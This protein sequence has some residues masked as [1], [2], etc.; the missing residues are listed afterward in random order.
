MDESRLVAAA[1]EAR[2]R[3]YAPY[4]GF[5]V[6]AALLSKGGRLFTGCNVENASYGLTVCAERV[7]L[8]KAVSEGVREFEAI[9]VA[10]GDGPCSPCGACR[11]A[12]YEFAPDLKVILAD[13]EGRSWE[14]T[15]LPELLPRA[16]GPSDLEG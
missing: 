16:F 3:A 7:A 4:S 2:R 6:G 13:A 10:C 9:A 8:F 15:S 11:Q 5:P 12:L 1:V 14:V